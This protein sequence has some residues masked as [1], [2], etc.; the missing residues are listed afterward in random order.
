MLQQ[1]FAAAQ[2]VSSYCL[3][4]AYGIDLD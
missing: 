4:S 1:Y 3:P 2:N